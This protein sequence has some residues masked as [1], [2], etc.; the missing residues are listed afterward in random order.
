[1]Y[2]VVFFIYLNII[3]MLCIYGNLYFNTW[4]SVYLQREILVA[5]SDTIYMTSDLLEKLSLIIITSLLIH[6]SK[7]AAQKYKPYNPLTQTANELRAEIATLQQELKEL[8]KELGIREPKESNK[9]DPSSSK[10]IARVKPIIKS[11][12]RTVQSRVQSNS[13]S[14]IEIDLD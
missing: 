7:M 12:P 6:T 2:I 11:Q 5:N 1:M 3:F 10:P 14:P 9:E 13:H 8:Q 4:I